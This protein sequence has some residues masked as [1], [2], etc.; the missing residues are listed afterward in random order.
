MRHKMGVI[1]I[2]EITINQYQEMLKFQS[3][4]R[5][6]IFP[7]RWMPGMPWHDRPAQLL[8]SS[9]VHIHLKINWIRKLKR[10]QTNFELFSRTWSLCARAAF[11]NYVG[12]NIK[13]EI[14]EL[15]E[16]SLCFNCESFYEAPQII[17]APLWVSVYQLEN[18][19]GISL[20]KSQKII[21]GS[22]SFVFPWKQVPSTEQPCTCF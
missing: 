9:L 11:V 2:S 22:D 17:N 15:V 14:M 16:S 8:F 6:E 10:N 13:I 7:E 18:L 3:I 19:C 5:G 4:E 20:F 1:Y 12:G 21:W